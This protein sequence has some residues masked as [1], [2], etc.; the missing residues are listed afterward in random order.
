MMPLL[1]VL[2]FTAFA[3]TCGCSVSTAT[4]I[5]PFYGTCV[6]V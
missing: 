2:S 3:F 1:S 4:W 5:T 6:R